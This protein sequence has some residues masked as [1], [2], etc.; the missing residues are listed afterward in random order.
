VDY[1]SYKALQVTRSGGVLTITMNNPP[2]NPVTPPLHE[3]LSRIFFD[4]NRDTETKVVVLTGAGKG[5]SAGGDIVNMK[6][7]L[8]RH[9]YQPWLRSMQ[10]A[11]GIVSGLLQLERPLISRVNGH[12]MGL[13]ATLAVFADFSYM[14]ES[15]KIA[16][17]H[18]KVGLT[19]G[20]GGS[21]MWPFLVGFTRAKQYLLTGDVLTG[22]QAAEIGLVTESAATIE[23]LDEKV[24]AMAG[25]LAG[26][27]SF[28]VNMTKASINLVLRSVMDRLIETHLGWETQSFLH[29]D[30]HE[31][32]TA[33]VEKRDPR[34]L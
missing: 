34:F 16:D 30:H 33:F 3:E 7:R 27:A 10:E 14:L 2:L 32:V 24:R 31:A 13:G 23:E 5:F 9:D 12:A 19:A 20:D 1:Q 6:S 29:P 11:K 4:V 17:T 28:A 8:D 25:K 22:K 21:L 15:A 26:G 18:V